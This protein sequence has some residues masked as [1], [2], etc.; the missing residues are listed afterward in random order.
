[1]LITQALRELVCGYRQKLNII[2]NRGQQRG[3][4]DFLRVI[5]RNVERKRSKDQRCRIEGQKNE[6]HQSKCELNS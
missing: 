1:M 3:Y 2:S 5:Q 4:F 6:T